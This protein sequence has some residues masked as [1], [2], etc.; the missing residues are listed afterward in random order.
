MLRCVALLLVVLVTACA[1]RD[2][3]PPPPLDPSRPIAA[4]DCSKALEPGGGNLNC[5]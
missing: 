5:R 4:H 2:L 1:S 3:E